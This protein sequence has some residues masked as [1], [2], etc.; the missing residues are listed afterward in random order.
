[1]EEIRVSARGVVAGDGDFCAPSRD[2][3]NR[4]LSDSP[5]RALLVLE[6]FDLLAVPCPRF[7]SFARGAGGPLR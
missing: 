2:E 1:L 4:I 6:A 3:R 5:F 7:R